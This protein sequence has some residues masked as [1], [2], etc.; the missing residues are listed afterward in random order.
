VRAVGVETLASCSLARQLRADVA[1]LLPAASL[2]VA[3]TEAE[4][5]GPADAFAMALLLANLCE[6][7]VPPGDIPG[8]AEPPP[9]QSFGE[10]ARPFWEHSGFFSNLAACLGAA[11][12]REPWPEGSGAYHRPWKLCG[13]CLRLVSAGFGHEMR[14]TVPLLMA[15][16]EARTTAAE[17]EDAD[18]ARA[19]RL[20]AAA[21]WELAQA[22][23]ADG[24]T[25]ASLTGSTSLREALSLMQEEEP[26]SL[27]QALAAHGGDGHLEASSRPFNP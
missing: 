2:S 21:L 26:A 25:V 4:A 22:E 3:L 5:N 17:A 19:A 14:E 23:D 6:L 16:V 1:Q 7:E 10:L 8:D 15:A 13:T 12:R 18:S 24:Q 27:L 20:A 11:Q 9:V